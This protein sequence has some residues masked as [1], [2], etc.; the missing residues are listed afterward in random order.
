MSM[1][2][3]NYSPGARRGD[4]L[5]EKKSSSSLNCV[6]LLYCTVVG[7]ISTLVE[8]CAFIIFFLVLYERLQ[9]IIMSKK[10]IPR[11]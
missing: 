2:K 9:S 3:Q 4:Q 11:S 7:K 8:L 5:A 10:S 1:Q 6:L